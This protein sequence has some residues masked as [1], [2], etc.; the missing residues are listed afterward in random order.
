MTSPAPPK[1]PPSAP[2]A[3]PPC[4][5]VC[6]ECGYQESSGNFTGCTCGVGACC[7]RFGYCNPSY[8]DPSNWYYA[9]RQIAYSNAAGACSPPP[10][11]PPP[12]PEPPPPPPGRPRPPPPHQE[13]PKHQLRVGTEHGERGAERAKHLGREGHLWRSAGADATRFAAL[14]G[15]VCLIKGDLRK[16]MP[17]A[18]L[19]L[20]ELASK[21]SEDQTE[22]TPHLEHIQLVK[23]HVT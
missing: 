22:N 7:S 18:P 6:G 15:R 8:C 2:P 20:M 4:L 16:A 1:S 3:L 13:Q 5:P 9:Q 14:V 11:P 17:L 10:P 12:P 23:G 19:Q 21:G